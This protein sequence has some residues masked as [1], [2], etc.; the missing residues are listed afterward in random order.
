MPKVLTQAMTIEEDGA[1][2]V[3]KRHAAALISI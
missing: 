3:I 1:E 2:S